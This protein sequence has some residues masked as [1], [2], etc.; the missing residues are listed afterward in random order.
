M[1]FLVFT[2]ADVVYSGYHGSDPLGHVF[3][4][5]ITQARLLSH[6]RAIDDELYK[7]TIS[8]LYAAQDA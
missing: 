3:G 1:L 5:L 8:N 4:Q 7:R 6:H 2:L